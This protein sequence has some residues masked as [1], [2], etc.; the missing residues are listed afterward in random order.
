[1]SAIE[2]GDLLP[3][4]IIEAI[5]HGMFI[6]VI[7][8]LMLLNEPVL[9]ITLMGSAISSAMYHLC[10]LGYIFNPILLTTLRRGDYIAISCLEV[11][12]TLRFFNL[13]FRPRVK[14]EDMLSYYKSMYHNTTFAIGVIL[15]FQ[16]V[17]NVTAWIIFDTWAGTIVTMGTVVL[18]AYV[19]FVCNHQRLSL[20]GYWV[21]LIDLVIMAFAVFLLFYAG[22][23]GD[24]NYAFPHGTWHII[25]VIGLWLLAMY[26]RIKDFKQIRKAVIPPMFITF[27]MTDE[28]KAQ[29]SLKKK[30]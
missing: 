21:F 24:E 30:T 10:Q 1:M 19:A 6:P 26:I 11:A 27:F 3:K 20:Y 2:Q 15:C 9:W 28:E 14:G 13:T 23:P 12:W 5:G 16:V 4:E 17:N 7:I 25:A 18:L 8:H 22:N 29:R